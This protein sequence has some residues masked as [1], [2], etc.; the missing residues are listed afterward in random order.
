MLFPFLA[1]AAVITVPA[2]FSMVAVTAMHEH[3][4]QRAGKQ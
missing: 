2:V 3:V 4:Q 1:L